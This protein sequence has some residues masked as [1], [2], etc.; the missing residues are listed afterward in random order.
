MK[1]RIAHPWA[2]A[3]T[4]AVASFISYGHD[5]APPVWR[6]LEGSTLSIW[7]FATANNPADLSPLS[8]NPFGSPT[9]TVTVGEFGSGWQ[10]TLLGLGTQTGF[11]DLGGEGGQIELFIP[12]RPASPPGSYKDLR[13]Q[14]TYFKDISAAPTVTLAGA[15]LVNSGFQVVESVPTGGQWIASWT[16]WRIEPNPV[17]ETI[18]IKSDADWGSVVDQI[19]VDTIC[20]VPEPS[21]VAFAG[22]VALGA[23]W[24]VRRRQ[25]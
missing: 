25:G 21:S 15:T 5:V 23:I 20:V 22:V 4:A 14:V 2:A 12:N 1:T 19:V 11:W 16:D 8:V 7:E 9:A 17:S 24:F 13:I 6:G 10:N 18:V 3:L